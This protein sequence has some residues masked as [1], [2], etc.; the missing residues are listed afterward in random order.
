MPLN[1]TTKQ[2]FTAGQLTKSTSFNNSKVPK[3]KQLLN[4][5]PQKPKILK[6][7]WSSILKKE[8]PIS[9]TTKSATFKKPKPPEPANKAKSSISPP[10]EEPKLANQLGS[11]NLASDQCSSILGTPSTTSVVAPAI[12]KIDTTAQPLAT[13]NNTAD[14]NNLGT[15]HLQGGK[16][17]IGNFLFPLDPIFNVP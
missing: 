14:L 7:S 16:N 1:E 4:E 15:A 17:Y 10:A 13:G 11:Q 2:R 3:V 5:V 6:E 8:A 12:L 9:M